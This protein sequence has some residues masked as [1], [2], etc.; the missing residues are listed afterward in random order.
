MY[1]SKDWAIK[2]ASGL[3]IGQLGLSQIK[4]ITNPQNKGTNANP[5]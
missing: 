2:N 3:G 1:G 4:V 5:R